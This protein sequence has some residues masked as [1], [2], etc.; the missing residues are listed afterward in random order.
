MALKTLE[1]GPGDEVITSA[2]SFI[3]IDDCIFF[4]NAKPDFADIN[5][6]I[7]NIDPTDVAEKITSKT[8]AVILIH[9][10]VNQQK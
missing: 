10:S 4:Q 9:M 1:L 5:S 3:A 8:K 7:F 2:F 6:R